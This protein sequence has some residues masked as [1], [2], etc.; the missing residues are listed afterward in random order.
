MTK[1]QNGNIVT[2]V[3]NNSDNAYLTASG[4]TIRHVET[5]GNNTPCITWDRPA[6]T[7]ADCPF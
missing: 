1:L 4:Y 5:Y 6:L 7:D 3:D 2:D